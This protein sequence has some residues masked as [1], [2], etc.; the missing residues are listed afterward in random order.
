MALTK[1]FLESPHRQKQPPRG[2]PSKRCSENMQQIYRK[3]PCRSAISIKLL[4]NFIETA[5]RHGCSLVNL[6]HIFRTPFL[7]NTSGWLLLSKSYYHKAFQFVNSLNVYILE[8]SYH[9]DQVNQTNF[10]RNFIL[11]SEN[12]QKSH[13]SMATQYE[14]TFL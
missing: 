4:C 3:H 8:L 10:F 12:R 9:F 13:I 1:P 6:L 14:V 11:T 5:F 7:K 2:V